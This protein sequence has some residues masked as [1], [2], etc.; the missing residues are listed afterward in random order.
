MKKTGISFL[1]LLF[2]LSFVF[3]SQVSSRDTHTSE[4]TIRFG[5][6]LTHQKLFSYSHFK[7]V[8]VSFASWDWITFDFELEEKTNGQFR[9]LDNHETAN[10]RGKVI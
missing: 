1:S 10:Y 6:H 5:K 3:A 9:V 8:N 4:A 2:L 7:G